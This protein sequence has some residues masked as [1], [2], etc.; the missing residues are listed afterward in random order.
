MRLGAS[1]LSPFL[2]LFFALPNKKSAFA[3]R[4]DSL[5]GV[6]F[7]F[8]Q[9]IALMLGL[10]V[11]LTLPP[12]VV[13][14]DVAPRGRAPTCTVA[15]YRPLLRQR[16]P[17]ALQSAIAAAIARWRHLCWNTSALVGAVVAAG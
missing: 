13:S 16:T 5:V 11:A 1:W 14:A 3:F 8:D 6:V 15:W 7:E 10:V 17:V 4:Q 2:V 9:W 12:A